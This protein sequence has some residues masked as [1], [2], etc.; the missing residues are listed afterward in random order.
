MSVRYFKDHEII[1][2]EDNSLSELKKMAASAPLRRARY[3]LHHDNHDIV[4]EMVIAFCR[5]S[6]VRPH[7]HTNKSESFHMIEG[8]LLVVFF[9][10]EG[11]VERAIAMKPKGQGGCF[12]YRLSC[13]RWHT[14]IPLSEYVVIHEVT[15]GPFIKEDSIFPAWAPDDSRKEAVNEFIKGV[16]DQVGKLD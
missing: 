15:N 7:K 3:C 2:I 8:E 16:K 4:H 1:T 5:D 6:Y 11:K 9:N 12:L 13:E 14:V 10:E